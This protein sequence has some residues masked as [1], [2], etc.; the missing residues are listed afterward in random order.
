MQQQ[1]G[2]MLLAA[3]AAASGSTPMSVWFGALVNDPGI[4]QGQGVLPQ[5]AYVAG[6]PWELCCQRG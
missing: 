4:E 2:G 1:F 5:F 6:L 3:V